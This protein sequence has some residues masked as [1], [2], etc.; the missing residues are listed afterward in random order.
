VKTGQEQQ[1]RTIT[2]NGPRGER[3]LTVLFPDLL[4]P[5][6]AEERTGLEESILR[7]GIAVSILVDQ[8]DG[9]IDGINRAEIAAANLWMKCPIDVRPCTSDE[10]RRELALALNEHRRHLSQE[11]LQRLRQERIARVADGRHEGKSLRA[12]AEQEKVSETQVR[13][14]IKAATAYGCAVEPTGGKVTGRDGKKR[15]AKRKPR[16]TPTG[17]VA[18]IDRMVEQGQLDRSDA[19]EVVDLGVAEQRKLGKAG[20]DAVKAKVRDMRYLRRLRPLFLYGR[21]FDPAADASHAAQREALERIAA[22]MEELNQARETLAGWI[23]VLQGRLAERQPDE[24]QVDPAYQEMRRQ[25]ATEEAKV[26]GVGALRAYEAI[27]CL[28]RIP[29]KDQLRKRGFQ[30]VEDWLRHNL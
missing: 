13:K 10:E 22:A 30:I 5:L 4:R 3:T 14:D 24:S 6:T 21:G 25:C 11:D 18:V 26:G 8:H 28:K 23:A 7:D 1:R 9:I 12:L 2:V 29:Q 20:V 16:H 15:P 19:E 17:A 27:N